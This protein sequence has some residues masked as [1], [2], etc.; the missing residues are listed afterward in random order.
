MK[1]IGL[2]VDLKL[3]PLHY[4]LDNLV[5][6]P[7]HINTHVPHEALQSQ[8]LQH[9]NTSGFHSTR[10]GAATMQIDKQDSTVLHKHTD[11]STVAGAESM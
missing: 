8:L 10:Q 9:P 1:H 5:D 6:G 2:V 4:A 7:S 3:L 11:G